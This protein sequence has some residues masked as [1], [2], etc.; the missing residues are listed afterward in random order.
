[1]GK[2]GPRQ[3]PEVSAS[4]LVFLPPFLI[5]W[6]WGW[7]GRLYCLKTGQST[8]GKVPLLAHVWDKKAAPSCLHPVHLQGLKGTQNFTI[9]VS[10]VQ[11]AGTSQWLRRRKDSA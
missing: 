4:C 3:R 1:M 11:E 6:I 8:H 5:G 10:H 7:A 2:D 9:T